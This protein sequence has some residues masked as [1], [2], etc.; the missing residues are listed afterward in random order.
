M[1]TFLPYP[2]FEETAA[3]LDYRRLGKQRVEAFQIHNIITQ[4]DYTGRWA[5]HPAVKMWRGYENALKLYVNVM[6]V[7]WSA[8]ATG[9]PC[10]TTISRQT[11]LPFPGGWK[12]PPSMIHTNRT[13]YANSLNITANSTGTYR[14]ICLMYGRCKFSYKSLKA[15]FYELQ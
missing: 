9:T 8:G 7:E 3:I 2:S 10:S 15:C 13:C 1:Q 14:T 4:P 5:N 6:I 11:K 12:I